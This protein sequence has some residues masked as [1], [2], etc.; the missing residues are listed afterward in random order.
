MK[1]GPRPDCVNE[2][3][4]EM[5]PLRVRKV[6]KMVS[7]KVSSTSTMFHTRSMSFFSWIIT[8]WRYAVD[9]SHGMKAVM[10]VAVT[11]RMRSR[12]RSRSWTWT[13]VV[14]SVSMTAQK[15]SEPFWPPQSAATVYC[16]GSVLEEY[17]A[18]YSSEKSCARSA[19]SR[20][21]TATTTS[22]NTAYAACAPERTRWR[23]RRIAPTI[24]TPVA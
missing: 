2:W 13:I 20:M 6:P 10:S 15:S 1:K 19:R 23:R 12:F 14:K 24:E 9:T 18:T 21:A 16:T 5:T 22:A 3:T 7:E 4:E 17:A 8:E 11:Q